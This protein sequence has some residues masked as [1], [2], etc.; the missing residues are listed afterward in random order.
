M[1]IPG[2]AGRRVDFISG[3]YTEPFPSPY[4]VAK[5]GFHIEDFLTFIERYKQTYPNDIYLNFLI[6]RGKDTFKY[7]PVLNRYE[8]NR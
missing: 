6:K 7:Y 8:P 2:N 4:V 1:N 3:L 5:C